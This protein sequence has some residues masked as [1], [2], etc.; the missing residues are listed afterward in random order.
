MKAVSPVVITVKKT[1]IGENRK[2]NRKLID[3]CLKKTA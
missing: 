3:S 1:Q 2:N